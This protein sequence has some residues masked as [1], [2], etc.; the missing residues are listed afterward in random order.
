MM[1]TD[2]IEK[3]LQQGEGYNL[4]Y[5]EGDAKN[6]ASEVCA[7]ANAAGGTSRIRPLIRIEVVD[8]VVDKN[9]ISSTQSLFSAEK[10]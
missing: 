4:E 5:K 9:A 10:W 8:K 7:F 6:V 2:Y 1:N 3:L